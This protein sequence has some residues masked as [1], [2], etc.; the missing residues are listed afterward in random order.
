M[1]ELKVTPIR[2]GTVIDHIPPGSALKVLMVLGLPREGS[3][4][5]VTVAMNASSSGEQGR[6]D[7]VKIEDRELDRD[8]LA[9]LAVMAPDA[10]ISLI[11][12][13]EVA[14]KFSAKEKLPAPQA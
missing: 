11:R 4:S 7:I 14:K 3:S 2:N 13:Y 8:E 10:T 1:K 5:S 6:K 9:A 12:N